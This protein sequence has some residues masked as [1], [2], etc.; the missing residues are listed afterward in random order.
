VK[1]GLNATCIG[2][3]ASGA[4]QRFLGLYSEVARRLPES[5]FV[6][7]AP[8][9]A[10]L[11]PQFADSPNVTV[12][13]TPIPSAG[14][15][16]KLVA[17]LR[18]WRRELAAERYDV[19]EL[20]HLPAIKAP[21]GR[22]VLTI[23]DIRGIHPGAGVVERSVYTASLQQSLRVADHVITVSQ[24]M[25][26]EILAAFPGK[27]ISVVYNGLGA[28]SFQQPTAAELQRV[29]QQYALPG[30][31]VLAVGHFEARKNY[32]RLI[33]AMALLRDRGQACPLV[34]VGNDS[35]FKQ[36]V[37]RRIHEAHLDS[38]VT[39]L[40][41]LSDAQLRCIYQLCSL[42]VFP[43]LYEGF[44]IPILEAMAAGRP[45]VLSALPAFREITEN[46]SVYLPPD[47]TALMAAAI[48]HVLSSASDRERLMAYGAQRI[49]SFSYQRLSE[50]LARLYR[51]IS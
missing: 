18:Y 20:F 12:K 16:R 11:A 23:H 35:G 26:D 15:V 19:F 31:F 4:R 2:E 39:L 46:Q 24:A 51:E 13:R 30:Q 45:M 50:Q 6:I 49:Q 8:V 44:G 17:G 3:R 28:Q 33:D 5:E 40:Y 38:S 47:D 41:D 42:F 37:M 21:C 9:D 43:S 36:Q 48:A 25:K 1:I 27:N 32:L 7:Y 29:R 22:T 34:I 10:D 14:R